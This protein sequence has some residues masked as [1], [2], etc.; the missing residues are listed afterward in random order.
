MQKNIKRVAVHEAGH[1]VMYWALNRPFKYVTIIPNKKGDRTLDG[2]G[3]KHYFEAIGH[4]QPEKRPSWVVELEGGKRLSARRRRWAEEEIITSLGPACFATQF[5]RQS[6]ADIEFNYD[7]Q[8]IEVWLDYLTK[9]Y[10]DDN[11]LDRII[12][13]ESNDYLK[14]RIFKLPLFKTLLARTVGL[15][16][17][18]APQ[19]W[20]VAKALQARRTLMYSDFLEV[21]DPTLGR[22]VA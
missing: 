1:A 21:V 22:A 4:I 14:N 3:E 8:S 6:L 18:F 10:Q 2:S 16:D 5:L 9:F 20:V 17:T 11:E 19:I 15:V 13:P 12:Q 7:F